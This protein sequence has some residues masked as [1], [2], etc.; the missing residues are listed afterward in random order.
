LK[1]KYQNLL[2]DKPEKL[3]IHCGSGVTACHTILALDYAGFPFRIYMLV[4]GANGAEEKV[5]KLR[6]KFNFLADCAD[7]ADFKN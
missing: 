4:L 1:E 7:S 2:L 6:E 3:I 5:R